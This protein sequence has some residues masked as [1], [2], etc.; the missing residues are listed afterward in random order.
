[1]IMWR[2]TAE[3]AV[4]P[5]AFM[6]RR[7][8]R[9]VP[10]YWSVTS[11]MVGVLLVAPSLLRSARFDLAHIIASYLFV[12]WQRPPPYAGPYPL[13]VPGWTLNYEM[14]F[15]ALFST[16]LTFPARARGVFILGALT[17]FVVAGQFCPHL[18]LILRVYSAPIVL[19]F[20]FG[21]AIAMLARRLHAPRTGLGLLGTGCALLALLAVGEST[22]MDRLIRLGI[23]AA[24]IVA[25]AALWEAG[26]TV[27]LCQFAMLMGNASYSIYLVHT[28]WLAALATVWLMAGVAVNNPIPLVVVGVGT[29]ITLGIMVHFL[30]ERPMIG[31]L[32]G[33]H[34]PSVPT[35]R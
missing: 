33:R 12:A 2:V 31:A 28:P 29:S 35:E 13:L 10:L 16:A 22:G 11:L 26:R 15:Y 27:P 18:P 32:T 14:F 7:L 4:S 25:G 6:R 19:E 30:I 23:P 8:V 5:L 9:V 20:G 34:V 21:I 1:M 24:L 3:R 17:V